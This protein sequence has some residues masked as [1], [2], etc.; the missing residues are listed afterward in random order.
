VAGTG[1]PLLADS[2][3]AALTER[4]T[5]RIEREAPAAD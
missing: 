2:L 1:P 5:N 3:V 4:L